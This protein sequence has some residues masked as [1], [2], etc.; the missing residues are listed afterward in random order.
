[1]TPHSPV[2]PFRH[3]HGST[4]SSGLVGITSACS[5]VE[6]WA[7]IFCGALGAVAYTIGAK[8]CLKLRIDDP[9]NATAVHFF[10]GMWGLL[11]PALFAKEANMVAATYAAGQEGLFY[12]GEF[13]MLWTQLYALGAIVA[14][15]TM[16]MCPFFVILKCAGMFRVSA[17]VEEMGMDASEHGGG[18]YHMGNGK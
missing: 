13:N 12:S 10:A 18:A 11:A 15:V 17:D 7:A 2:L 16:N 1:L 4:Q 9:V 3:P 8:L 14:W 5:V 6:P